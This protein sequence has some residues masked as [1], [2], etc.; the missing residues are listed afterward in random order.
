MNT[1]SLF[2]A[3]AASVAVALGSTAA[4]A[5]GV[6]SPVLD[7]ATVPMATVAPAAGGWEGGYVGGS[8]GYSFGGDD[9]VGLQI[10]ENGEQ[11]ARAGNLTDLKISGL[12]A[13][14]HAGYR[15]Q[16]DRWVFG[17][18][19]AI[20]GGSVD[21]SRNFT[22]DGETSTLESK[23]NHI[24]S[25]VMKTGYT[26]DPQTMVFG[27]FGVSR[28]DAEY[29]SSDNEDREKH[30]YTANGLTAGFGVE[31]MVNPTTSVFAAY[32][33]RDYGTTNIDSIDEDGEIAR[34]VATPKHSN[35]KVGI[36]FR[37]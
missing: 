27:T 20:V 3:L 23:V 35:I 16:R 7:V 21:A 29:R 17:P 14:V 25:L 18:E 24:V 30:G 37:F 31:R 19:L 9:K 6:I 15:W 5:G 33:Y 2:A 34:T 4:L 28:I 1:K 8:L 12:T 32:Q 10:L 36:N 11:V 13:G 22:F 26:I